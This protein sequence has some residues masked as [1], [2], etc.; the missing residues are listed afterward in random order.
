MPAKYSECIAATCKSLLIP[1][2]P[3]G[4]Q[5]PEVTSL[6]LATCDIDM[7]N[8]RPPTPMF[9]N[10]LTYF[11]VRSDWTEPDAVCA[12]RAYVPANSRRKIIREEIRRKNIG[13]KVKKA[14]TV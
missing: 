2:R 9:R 8:A 13:L 14:L 11:G 3:A 1:N 4:F 7:P 10:S 5:Y 6:T 12:W